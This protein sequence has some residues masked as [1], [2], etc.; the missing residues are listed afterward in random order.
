MF[1]GLNHEQFQLIL[2]TSWRAVFEIQNVKSKFED[3]FEEEI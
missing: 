3:E 2:K 1:A